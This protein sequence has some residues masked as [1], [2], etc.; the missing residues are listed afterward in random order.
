MNKSEAFPIGKKRKEIVEQIKK[1]AADFKTNNGLIEILDFEHY[2][3]IDS[4]LDGPEESNGRSFL[5]S[6]RN[7]LPLEHRKSLRNYIETVLKKRE[8]QAI[9]VEFGGIGSRLFREFTLGFFAKSVAVSLVDHRGWKSK[10]DKLKERDKK[11]HHEVLEGDIFD[12]CTYESLNKLLNNE[13]IDL[14]IERMGRGLEFV[15]IEPYAISKILQVWYN[16]LREGGIMFVQTPAV[17]NNLLTA[18]VAKIQREFNGK[19]EI[20]YSKNSIYI[21]AG[22]DFSS[23]RLHKLPGAPNELPLLDPRVVQKITKAKF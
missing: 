10:L 4:S 7:V 2:T 21:S 11:I 14:I 13:K 17:F 6:F 22:C 23:F 8:G 16:L 19:I 15:P 5:D 12:F 1:E 3:W 9:G 20:Q 18:W